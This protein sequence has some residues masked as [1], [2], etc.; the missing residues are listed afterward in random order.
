[1]TAV[2]ERTEHSEVT[3]KVEVEPE[4]LAKATDRAY[5]RLVQRVSIPG[6]RKGKAPRKILERAVGLDALYREALDF[7]MPD[8][9]REAVKETGISPYTQPEFEVL[10]LEPEKPLVFKAVVPVQPTIKLG[11]YKTLKLDPPQL[12]VTDADIDQTVN[13]LRDSHAQL[14][15]VEDRP[16]RIGDQVTVDVVTRL[17]GKQL[18]DQPRETILGLDSDNPVPSWANAVAGLNVGDQKDVEDQIAPDYREESIAGKIATYSV[19][20]KAIKQRELPDLDDELARSLG[21]YEDLSALRA[22]VRKR[23]EVQKKNAA[24]EQYETELVDK[25][26]EISEIDYPADM[27]EQ[28]VDQMQR[29]ADNNFRRQGFSLEMFLRGTQKSLDAMRAEW[30]PRATH[31]LKTALVL[32]ELIEAEKLELDRGK[33]DVELYRMVEDQPADRRDDVR[34]LV[35]SERVRD[36]VQQELLL[37][38]ALDLLDVTAGGQQFV[39][40]DEVA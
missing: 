18:G 21:D 25:L 10:E 37:R 38:K 24:R 30:E 29:E 13:N 36:S 2:V 40:S 12:A 32:R 15:P 14:V 5:Q 7:V 3:L 8:A 26:I 28:E 35:A 33:L 23:L 1:M 34:K 16:A 17:D 39:E 9:Y 27:V 19:T 4:R 22:D 11:D 6:F 20:V 31:R